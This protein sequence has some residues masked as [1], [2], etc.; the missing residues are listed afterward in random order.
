MASSKQHSEPV[1]WLGDLTG[2]ERPLAGGK[3]GTLARLYQA[4]YPV[5]DGFVVLPSAFAGDELRPETWT[6]VRAYLQ[7]MRH[8]R[9]RKTQWRPGVR[10]PERCVAVA[11]RSSAVGEDSAQASFA[12][13]FETVLD[14]ATDGAIRDA[15]HTVRRSRDS[16]R[17]R[18]YSQLQDL[19]AEHEM[20][21]I[22]QRLVLTEV[23]GVL[24]TADP[25]SGS[26]NRMV[27]NLV[28]G[29]GEK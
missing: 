24:F 12:G 8:G 5:P 21:I 26:H 22:V 1:R 29:P 15:I 25:V 10:M 20:A 7:R 9:A 17:V 18:A 2:D 19:E 27:G 23:S 6:Q 4:G 16:E 3:G 11:V 13:E 28:L 14:V